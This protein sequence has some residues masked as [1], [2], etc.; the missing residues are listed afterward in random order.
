MRS[1]VLVTSAGT[2]SELNDETL[3]HEIG[4]MESRNY[5]TR[6]HCILVLDEAE[7]IHQL[8]LSDLAGAVG[9]EMG[10]YLGLGGIARQVAQVEAS[11]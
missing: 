7:A 6:V 10:L 11:G 2:A 9:L 1:E 3:S 4:T 5:V 8:N